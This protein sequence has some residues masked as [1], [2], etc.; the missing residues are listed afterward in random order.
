MPQRRAGA[1]RHDIRA[2]VYYVFEPRSMDNRI[3]P[4]I[5]TG[6]T[7]R[8]GQKDA[9]AGVRLDQVDVRHTKNRQDEAGET[10]AATHVDEAL[11]LL[12]QICSQLG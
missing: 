6:C 11:Y 9:F 1:R 12:G 7:S 4:H 3:A 5:E 2:E 8:L 10:G